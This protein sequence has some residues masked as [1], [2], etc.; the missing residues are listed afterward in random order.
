[1]L[2]QHILVKHG[3]KIQCKRN[4]ANTQPKTTQLHN[5]KQRKY[6]TQNNANTQ[7][8]TTQIHNPKQRS[9]RAK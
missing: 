4:N 3:K 1:M 8:K 5:P 2:L 9:Q 7:P 6:T